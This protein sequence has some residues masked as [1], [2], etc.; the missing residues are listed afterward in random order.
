MKPFV[1]VLVL[2]LG[3]AAMAQEKPS[4]RLGD[5]SGVIRFDAQGREPNETSTPIGG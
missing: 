5:E 1:L 4:P 3:G 2:V